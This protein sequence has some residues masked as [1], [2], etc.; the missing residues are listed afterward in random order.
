MEKSIDGDRRREGERE[1][2]RERESRRRKRNRDPLSVS[3]SLCVLKESGRAEKR[4][5]LP[6]KDGRRDVE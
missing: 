4:E 5:Q 1:R 3:L 2:E 6:V